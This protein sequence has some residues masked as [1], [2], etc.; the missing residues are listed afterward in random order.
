MPLRL[1]TLAMTSSL[2]MSA[3]ARTASTMLSGVLLRC[4]RLLRGRRCSVWTPPT[5]WIVSTISLVVS[6]RSAITSLMTVRTMR[7]F[8]LASV[9]GAPQTAC[10]SSA[11]DSNDMGRIAAR[12]AAAAS[13]SA[14]RRS[15][16]T[17]CASARFQ[18]A[19]SSPVTSRFSGSAA[20]YCRNAR[21]AA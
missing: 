14:I 3:N 11:S 15:I 19:S 2:A 12:G 20:S 21:S 8:S 4:P 18:R 7:F 17:T 5:Q 13:C 9:V 6:S 1:S 16:P 10:R